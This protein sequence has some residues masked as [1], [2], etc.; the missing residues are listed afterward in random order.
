MSKDML[1]T[2]YQLHCNICAFSEAGFHD[3]RLKTAV[4]DSSRPLPAS[5]FA[6]PLENNLD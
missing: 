3:K 2:Q 5:V 4:D 6:W 1:D